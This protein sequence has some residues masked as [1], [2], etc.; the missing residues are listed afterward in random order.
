MS[1]PDDRQIRV[2][3]DFAKR[4]A[5]TLADMPTREAADTLEALSLVLKMADAEPVAEQAA[6]AAVMTRE[7]DRACAKFALMLSEL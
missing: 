1:A 2:L 4:T 5:A 3:R 7:G 6:H